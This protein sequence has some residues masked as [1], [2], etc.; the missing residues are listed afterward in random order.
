MERH[1]VGFCILF[2][3]FE[4]GVCLANSRLV[5]IGPEREWKWVIVVDE[6]MQ[7]PE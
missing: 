2:I 6:E 7:K 4:V 3:A 1:L 5:F